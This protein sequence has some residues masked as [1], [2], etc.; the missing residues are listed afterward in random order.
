M[1]N[2]K[3]MKSL[4]KA[5][6]IMMSFM[7]FCCNNELRPNRL[8]DFK[9]GNQLDLAEEISVLQFFQI[10][11]RRG[12]P[13]KANAEI[14]EV[15]EDD[16]NVYFYEKLNFENHLYLG[17]RTFEKGVEK[18]F[19]VNKIALESKFGFYKDLHGID[20]RKQF[21]EKAG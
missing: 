14:T 21:L 3:A 9:K 1:G 5:L 6:L 17:H 10:W 15:Y 19:K 13:W 18:L 16:F 4:K 12:I 2:R 8:N 7:L 11:V 20:L